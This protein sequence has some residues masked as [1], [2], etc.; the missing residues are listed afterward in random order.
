LKNY[1]AWGFLEV[2]T[3]FFNHFWILMAISLKPPHGGLKI[4]TAKI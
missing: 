4:K 1:Y 3:D 2:P